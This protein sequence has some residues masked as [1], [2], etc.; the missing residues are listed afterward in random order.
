MTPDP[1]STGGAA[2]ASLTLCPDDGRPIAATRFQASG[3]R[4]GAMLIAGATGVPQRHYKDFA[5]H[6][7][8]LGWDVLT[9]DWRGIAD[10]RFGMTPCE[11]RLTMTRWGSEDLAAAIAWAERRVDGGPVVLV[12]HSFGGQA[13]ALASNAP[14][15]DAIILLGAQHGWYRHWP[16]RARLVLWPFWRIVMPVVTRLLHH[17]PSPRFGLGEPLPKGVALEWARWCRSPDYHGHWQG[18][19]LVTAP[20][21]AYSASDDRIAPRAAVEALLREYR[22]ANRVIHRHITPEGVGVSAIGH[23][24]FFRDGAVPGLWQECASFLDAAAAAPSL[25]RTPP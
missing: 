21:L 1:S 24:G 3:E 4:R 19:D 9:W 10:S 17:F 22:G 25:G 23:F 8:A 16:W 18:L 20:L 5:E 12:G 7:A 13:V 11:P 14:R 15:L 2:V 6:F